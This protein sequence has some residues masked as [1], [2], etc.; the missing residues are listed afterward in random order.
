MTPKEKAEELQ[1]CADR[2]R[3]IHKARMQVE[4]Q[5]L[6][7]ALSFYAAAT[8]AVVQYAN[9]GMGMR[10]AISAGYVALAVF[11]SALL[12]RLHAANQVNIAIAE[13][14]EAELIKTF[15]QLENPIPQRLRRTDYS[16]IK[17]VSFL[18]SN[19]GFQSVTVAGF[20]AVGII[21]IWTS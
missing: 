6:I 2:H 7:T 12:N 10:L 13:N 3:E 5:I 11:A 19:W 9:L 14:Y 17:P 21:V 15:E 18:A 1:K 4:Y 8:W 16:Q 20:A